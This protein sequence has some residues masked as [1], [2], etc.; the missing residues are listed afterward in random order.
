M[1]QHAVQL[2]LV[3]PVLLLGWAALER[4]RQLLV[5]GR[6]IG[7]T[8]EVITTAG[9][10]WAIVGLGQLNAAVWCAVEFTRPQH[11][12]AWY[13]WRGCWLIAAV[14]IAAC[15]VPAARAAWAQFRMPGWQRYLLAI[16][17]ELGGE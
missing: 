1:S 4:H 16:K 6:R 2:Y 14:V 13:D 15:I 9:L 11:G 17:L 5:R 8:G 12:H 3:L 7:C 10:Q